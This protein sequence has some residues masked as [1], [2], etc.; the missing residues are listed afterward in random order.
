MR[1]LLYLPIASLALASCFFDPHLDFFSGGGGPY[2][3]AEGIQF[4]ERAPVVLATGAIW[5]PS[6]TASG[7]VTFAADPPGVLLVRA[8]TGD[9]QAIAPGRATVSVE[10]RTCDRV[11]ELELEVRDPVTVAVEPISMA[12]LDPLPRALAPAG[13]GIPVGDGVTFG[14]IRRDAGGLVLQ[15]AFPNHWTLESSEFEIRPYVSSDSDHGDHAQVRS[16]GVTGT[17]QLGA[18]GAE[19]IEIAAID[20]V[21]VTRIAAHALGGNAPGGTVELR[22]GSN[23]VLQILGY[24]VAGRLVSQLE[25]REVAAAV[26][27]A[28]ASTRAWSGEGVFVD[29]RGLTPGEGTISVNAYGL[30]LEVPI[31]VVG[32]D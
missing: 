24:D 19:A 22:A 9:L 15:G 28:V 6:F 32:G 16:R 8:E 12:W 7:E 10:D 23:S 26:E 13:I 1:E 31:R 30:P 4:F 2:C 11:A 20:A 3:A 18:V 29:L 25:D 21:P 14:V 27:P 5:R 17:A